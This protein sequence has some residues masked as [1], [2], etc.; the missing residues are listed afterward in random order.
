[1]KKSGEDSRSIRLAEEGK[2]TNVKVD[3]GQKACS[4]QYAILLSVPPV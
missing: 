3:V 1:M 2:D 4:R